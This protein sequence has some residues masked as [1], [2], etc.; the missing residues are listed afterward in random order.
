MRIICAYPINLDAIHDVEGKEIEVLS[1]GARPELREKIASTDDLISVLLC[2]MREGSGAELLVEGEALARNIH[3]SFS[4]RYRLGGN[5]GI[6]ANVLAKLGAHP[7]LNAPALSRRMAEMLHPGVGVPVSGSLMDPLSAAGDQEMIH[8]VFQ[9]IEGEE[10]ITPLGKIVAQRDNRLIATFDPFNS[11]LQ[12]NPDFDSYC[13]KEIKD[14]DGA[15]VSGFH[16]VPLSHYKEIFDRKIDQIQ[17]WKEAN[18]A[19]YI[20]AEMGSF[21]RP[22]IMKYLMKRLPADSLGLNEDELARAV[23][24]ES[25]WKGMLDGVLQLK[26]SLGFPRV[27]VHARDFILSAAEPMISAESEMIALTRGADAAAAMASTGDIFGTPPEE[28]NPSGLK[29]KE[30]FCAMGADPLG[31]GAVMHSGDTTICFVPSLLV[32]HPR[33][34]VGLGDTATAAIFYEEVMARKSN[35]DKSKNRS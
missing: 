8:F 28:I 17:S 32:R 31:R 35:I 24:I 22:E 25:G 29:A 27:S 23:D 18:P 21:Q 10:V 11:R 12:T 15:L 33:F 16:L 7:V 5:A 26:R 9:F 20:H 13:R 19:I 14:F 6:M 30:D 3:S 34:T 2:C 4:W 1:E